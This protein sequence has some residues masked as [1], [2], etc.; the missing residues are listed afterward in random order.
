ML[1]DK[2]DHKEDKEENA[3]TEFSKKRP[4]YP[5]IHCERDMGVNKI[6]IIYIIYA[7]LYY[8]LHRTIYNC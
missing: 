1:L 2:F 7:M 3:E 6:A 8:L 4:E 5:E